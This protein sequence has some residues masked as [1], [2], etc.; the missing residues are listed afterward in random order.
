[1]ASNVLSRYLDLP[2]YRY[3]FFR[4]LRI[5]LIHFSYLLSPPN[6]IL[7]Q[8]ENAT[9][10]WNPEVQVLS[11][12]HPYN[13]TEW[14]PSKETVINPNS[15]YLPKGRAGN[16]VYR[17]A[18]PNH[19]IMVFGGLLDIIYNPHTPSTYVMTN[20]TLTYDIGKYRTYIFFG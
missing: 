10:S 20:E 11:A 19:P 8:I 4:L 9:G 3:P 15:R 2:S 12:F 18:L 14:I 7:S 1:M 5:F 17:L 16:S 6:R 13:G